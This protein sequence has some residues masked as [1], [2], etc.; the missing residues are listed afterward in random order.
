MP[1]IIRKKEGTTNVV[2]LPFGALYYWL[3]CPT[4]LVTVIASLVETSVM[5]AVAAAMW[6]LLI[7]LAVPY[8][9]VVFK[10]KKMMKEKAISAKGS[11]YSFRNPLRYEWQD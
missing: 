9:P 3:M 10:I 1:Y 11:K 2:V 7:G 4:I 8:W 6:V 5:T